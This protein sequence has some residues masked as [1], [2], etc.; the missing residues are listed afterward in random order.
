MQCIADSVLRGGVVAD[1]GTDHG[2]IP[3]WLLQNGRAEKVIMTDINEG[4]LAK[5]KRNAEEAGVLE[6]FE[7]RLGDGL[8]P[9]ADG[10]ADSVIIAGMGGELIARILED[11]P[12]KARSF[13]L[14]VF[15]PRTRS[16]VL[17]HWLC[18]N[19]FNIVG[20][21]LVREGGRICQ[22]LS[23]MPAE[24]SPKGETFFEEADYHVAPLLF[25]NRDPLLEDFLKQKVAN[26]ETVLRELSNSDSQDAERLREEWTEREKAFR[27]RL[28]IA[29]ESV[30]YE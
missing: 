29:S 10:E 25:W 28:Q 30:K 14:L 12:L 26:C 8:A 22:V 21:S 20:E 17:R 3:I 19:D 9:I 18:D 27:F 24:H 1:I 7:L 2:F 15:Q 16:S 23:A 4:P 5:A 6:G 13:P 11:D